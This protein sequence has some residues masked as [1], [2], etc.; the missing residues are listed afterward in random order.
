LF[1]LAQLGATVVRAEVWSKMH[2][3][4]GAAL[5]AVLF[6]TSTQNLRLCSSAEAGIVLKIFGAKNEPRVL[7]K[8]SVNKVQVL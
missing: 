5:A 7:I 8:K 6:T 2:F 1:V 3:A 4:N